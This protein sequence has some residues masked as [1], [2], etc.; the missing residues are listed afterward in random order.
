MVW[1]VFSYNILTV[2][3]KPHAGLYICVF[4]QLQLSMT[5]WHGLIG[6]AFTCYAGGWG[7]IP[8]RDSHFRLSGQALDIT[9]I[10]FEKST[11]S[12]ISGLT[13]CYAYAAA[14]PKVMET[15]IGTSLMRHLAREEN[16]L[17]A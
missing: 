8:G 6:K 17:T 4:Y 12:T 5:A 14:L 10:E 11:C 2:I 13:P 9:G 16:L 7:S 3:V 1:T 15:G